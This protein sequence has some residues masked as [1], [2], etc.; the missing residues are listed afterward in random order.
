[1]LLN[2]KVAKIDELFLFTREWHSYPSSL[3]ILFMPSLISL[4]RFSVQ[5]AYLIKGAVDSAQV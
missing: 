2:G 4:S 5:R 3:T 1:V